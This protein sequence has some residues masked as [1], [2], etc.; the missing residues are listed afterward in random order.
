MGY[1][2]KCK[3]NVPFYTL[4]LVSISRLLIY[5]QDSTGKY[6]LY[7][8]TVKSVP[9]VSKLLMAFRVST[10]MHYP[11]SNQDLLLLAQ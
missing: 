8:K 3:T 11:W 5:Q 9:Q 4:A 1:T 6:S 2:G 10:R 7:S